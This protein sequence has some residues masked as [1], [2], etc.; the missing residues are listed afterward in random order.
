MV[1]DNNGGRE[2]AVLGVVVGIYFRRNRIK[3]DGRKMPNLVVSIVLAFCLP[4]GEFGRYQDL[5]HVGA[6]SAAWSQYVAIAGERGRSF[7]GRRQERLRAPRNIARNKRGAS[8][9]TRPSGQ[10]REDAGVAERSQ[11]DVEMERLEAAFVH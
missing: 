4:G 7:P 6:L 3:V 1:G 5:P 8:A 2:I 9:P 10:N 11:R